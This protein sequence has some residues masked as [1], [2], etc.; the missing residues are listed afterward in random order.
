M[1][2]SISRSDSKDLIQMFLKVI[3]TVDM[4]HEDRHKSS[5]CLPV[6]IINV[7]SLLHRYVCATKPKPQ[8][9]IYTDGQKKRY[10]RILSD[11]TCIS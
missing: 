1:A 4:L 8:R 2:G 6:P 9:N 11:Y 7:W 10:N 5:G 3:G